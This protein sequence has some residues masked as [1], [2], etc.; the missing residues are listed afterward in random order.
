MAPTQSI[1]APTAAPFTPRPGVGA[2]KNPSPRDATAKNAINNAVPRIGRDATNAA[3]SRQR[4]LGLHSAPLAERSQS[5]DV[6]RYHTLP[7]ATCLRWAFMHTLGLRVRQRSADSQT[8]IVKISPLQCHHLATA[9]TSSGSQ[10][11]RQPLEQPIRGSHDR[12][13]LGWGGW[14]HIC[15]RDL[16][17]LHRRHRIDREHTQPGGTLKRTMQQL[18]TAAYPM[19]APTIGGELPV[20]SLH[21]GRSHRVTRQPGEAGRET[22][23]DR[24]NIGRLGW[25]ATV[26]EICTLIVD[27]VADRCSRGHRRS[28]ELAEHC[29]PAA[30][31][32]AFRVKCPR[33]ASAVVSD[34]DAPR[35][36]RGFLTCIC[37]TKHPLRPAR[38]VL[39][40]RIA[41][42]QPL[43]SI[44][45][46]RAKPYIIRPRL[47]GVGRFE[48]P[49]ST[50]RTW[51]A[52]QAAL[53]PVAGRHV[54]QRWL[55]LPQLLH[56]RLTVV[57]RHPV[58]S[59]TRR[60]RHHQRGPL[61]RCR[62]K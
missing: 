45:R 47:V 21:D 9:R 53:H 32:F 38:Q 49:A 44:P 26:V 3:A 40:P 8:I 4:H 62:L 33:T 28:A 13:D 37:C 50:S 36:C 39:P 54:I 41:P 11:Q 61:C 20:E 51:R 42:Q 12:R 43:R 48:L 25:G 18:V 14:M 60:V 23:G 16:R 10:A 17:W 19:R 15:V 2:I 7:A 35:T 27:D 24:L 46:I 1:Y 22:A 30:G 6:D 57:R 52:N 59:S 56:H 55:V 34:V 5:V 58:E 29:G 31:R